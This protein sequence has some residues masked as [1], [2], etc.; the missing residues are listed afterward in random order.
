MTRA[1]NVPFHALFYKYCLCAIFYIL[2]YVMFS[3][4]NFLDKYFSGAIKYKVDNYFNGCANIILDKHKIELC[5]NK[6]V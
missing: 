4:K 2:Y 5:S 6:T 3:E 1:A